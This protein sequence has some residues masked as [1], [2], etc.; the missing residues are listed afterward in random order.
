MAIDPN[1]TE[2]MT[3]EEPT[4]EMA[5]PTQQLDDNFTYEQFRAEE[6]LSLVRGRLRDLESQHYNKKLD[7][8]VVPSD[9]ADAVLEQAAD[10]EAKIIELR[11]EEQS[12]ESEQSNPEEPP[13]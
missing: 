1:P 4:E 7:L 6:R 9:Q 10:L 11:Q 12:V 3:T 8:Y 5:E 13:A 2:V